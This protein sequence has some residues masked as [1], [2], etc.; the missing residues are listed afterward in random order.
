MSG[1]VLLDTTVVI[2]HLRKRNSQLVQHLQNGGLLYL[3]LTAVGELH[4]GV[5][6]SS[7]PVKT[8]AGVNLLLK[9]VTVLYPDDATAEQYGRIY[10]ELPK[11]ELRFRK[12]IYGLRRLL[13]SIVFPL[14]LEIATSVEYLTLLS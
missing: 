12:T 11:R 14:P 10:A 7:Q 6:C 13:E 3:P 1:S 8:L 4:A 2:D 5:Q 9:S